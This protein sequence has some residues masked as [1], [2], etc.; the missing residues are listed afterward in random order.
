MTSWT[1]ANAYASERDDDPEPPDV[2]WMHKE[3]RKLRRHVEDLEGDIEQAKA[4]AVEM[5]RALTPSR[6][7]GS[8]NIHGRKLSNITWQECRPLL[9]MAEHFLTQVT[10]VNHEVT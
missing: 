6:V 1:E 10:G 2:D 3:I 8:T 4:M 9:L 5:V 7:F